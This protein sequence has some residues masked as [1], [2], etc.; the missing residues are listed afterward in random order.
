[1]VLFSVLYY[2]IL[3]FADRAVEQDYTI[4]HKIRPGTYLIVSC[5]YRSPS[6]YK[7]LIYLVA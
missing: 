6:Q 5:L 7:N 1:M 2:R 3:C 4:K